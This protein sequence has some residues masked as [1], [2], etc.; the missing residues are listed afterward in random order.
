M[1]ATRASIWSLLL[2]RFRIQIE[3]APALVRCSGWLLA[4]CIYAFAVHP[5][6]A[7]AMGAARVELD[8]VFTKELVAQVQQII[9]SAGPRKVHAWEKIKA[10][11]LQHNLAYET[12]CAPKYVCVHQSNRSSFGVDPVRV[13]EHGAT[14]VRGGFSWSKAADV[15]ALEVPPPP[16]QAEVLRLNQDLIDVS[17]GLLPPL[18]ERPKLASVGGS[19]TNAFLRALGASSKTCVKEF[20]NYL[21]KGSSQHVYICIAN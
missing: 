1:Q 20:G 14:I 4:F 13:H 16:Y 2:I 17:D 7:A 11:L 9:D 8:A 3:Q 10:L 6:A 12:Q 21:D 5:F 19:H 15:V 18:Q